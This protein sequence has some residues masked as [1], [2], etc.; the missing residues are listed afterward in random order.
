MTGD[1]A[2]MR[3]WRALNS[4]RGSF[5]SRVA[6]A[7]FLVT[8]GL[9]VLITTGDELLCGLSLFLAFVNAS[10]AM[11]QWHELR[12]GKPPASKDSGR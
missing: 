10:L 11:G 3:W 7:L 4:P 9:V 2:A 1:T 12:E 6:T 5:W 8:F